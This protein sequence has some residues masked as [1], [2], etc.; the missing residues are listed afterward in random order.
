M[1]VGMGIWTDGRTDG[2]DGTVEW[3][4]GRSRASETVKTFDECRAQ[5]FVHGRVEGAFS[6][7]CL[8]LGRGVPP[9]SP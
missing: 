5:L 4:V 2:T 8:S 7:R 1:D 3:T 6:F 9:W